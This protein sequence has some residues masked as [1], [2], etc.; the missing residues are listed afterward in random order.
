[1]ALFELGCQL[2]LLSQPGVDYK[3][4]IGQDPCMEIQFS[5]IRILNG[6]IKMR[7]LLILY[8]IKAE[9]AAPKIYKRA[10]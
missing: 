1:M 6:F 10:R 9:K 5:A 3:N 4:I 8:S 7:G 2:S